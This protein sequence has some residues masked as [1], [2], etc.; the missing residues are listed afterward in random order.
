MARTGVEDLQPLLGMPLKVLY[1]N[2]CA[3]LRD[4]STLVELRSLERVLLPECAENIEALKKLPN[5]Q[6]ISF[7]YDAKRNQP[8]CDAKHFW[9]EWRDL[10]WLRSLRTASVAVEAEQLSDGTWRLVV[11]DAA[12]SDLTRLTG[13]R[14]SVLWLQGTKTR[15]LAPL[16]GLPLRV[17]RLD[18]TPCNDVSALAAIPTLESLVLPRGTAG[19]EKL[20]ALGALKRLAFEVSE[21]GEPA[22]PA[23]V[24]WREFSREQQVR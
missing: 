17:L 1:A 20:R 6:R 23:D 5:L 14:I 15:E 8:A 21:N 2:E 7:T 11:K 19:I 13:A 16:A 18:S 24:F 9:Q 22:S 4:V 12:F 10:K 3:K